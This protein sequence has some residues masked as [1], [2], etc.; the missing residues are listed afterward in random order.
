MPFTFSM[1]SNAP[2]RPSADDQ[3]PAKKARGPATPAAASLVVL[4]SIKKPDRPQRLPT[5]A[6]LIMCIYKVTERAADLWDNFH[7]TTCGLWQ[8]QVDHPAKPSIIFNLRDSFN[9]FLAKYAAENE[10]A[11][12]DMD[13]LQKGGI[14]MVITDAQ[15]QPLGSGHSGVSHLT[16]LG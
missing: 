3:P 16:C 11:P 2:Q 7:G 9:G 13:S 10:G 5:S 4:D 1:T 14:R 6:D 15:I 8:I 12:S